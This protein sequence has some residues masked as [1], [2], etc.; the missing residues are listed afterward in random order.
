V[1]ITQ[2]S[3]RSSIYWIYWTF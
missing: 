1:T 3:S 2:T